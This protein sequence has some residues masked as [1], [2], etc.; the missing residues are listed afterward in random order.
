MKGFDYSKIPHSKFYDI[1]KPI[2]GRFGK[3]YFDFDYIGTENIPKEGGF[4]IAS[5]HIHAIDPGVIG[6]GI[7][8]RQL[9][10]MGKKEL[11]EKPISRWFY[12]HLNGFPIVRGGADTEA[13]RFAVRIV[14]EGH[15]LGIFPEGTRSDDQKPKRPKNGVA[16]IAKA[17]HANILPVALINTD[18][19]KFRSK[20]TV[21]FGKMIPYEELGLTEDGGREELKNASDYIMDKIIELWEEGHCE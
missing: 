8:G 20:Y 15:I 6:L 18:N 9:H 10:F 14:E 21:R 2:G 5:N 19:F 3:M 1:F 11:F 17:S 4:I 12:T 16:R 13:L 7:D